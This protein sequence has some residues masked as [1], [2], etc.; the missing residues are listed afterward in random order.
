M[1][2]ILRE[3]VTNLGRS[4]DVVA[5]R[6]GF[7]RNY[8]IPQ[9]LAVLATERNVKQIEHQKKVIAARNA[10]L[11]KDAQSVADRLGALEVVIT[12]QAGEGDKLFGSVS[13]RDIEAALKDMG[14]VVDRK[15]I[16]LADPIKALGDYSV[17]IKL[18]HS[19]SGKIKVRV[20]SQA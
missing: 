18:G 10:R 20:V 12:R 8:L 6:D 7:G 14:V 17:E 11:T 2:V 9:G 16:H 15:K 5:V 19:V 1:R 4:G 3:D 13:S